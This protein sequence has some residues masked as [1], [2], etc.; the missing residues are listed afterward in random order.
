MLLFSGD[1]HF[2]EF[3]R[4]FTCR[5]ADAPPAASATATAKASA[6]GELWTYGGHAIRE[7]LS[8]LFAILNGSVS[9][10]H[11]SS[12]TGAEDSHPHSTR[13]PPTVVTPLVEVTSSGL[14]HAW[15]QLAGG[16]RIFTTAVNMAFPVMNRQYMTN[17]DIASGSHEPRQPLGGDVVS[18]YSSL[19][20]TEWSL[21]GRPP[22]PPSTPAHAAAAAR[23]GPAKRLRSP[24]ALHRAITS[25]QRTFYAHRNF[26]T[27]EL[28]WGDR[29]TREAAAA[30]AR[31]AATLGGTVA[32]AAEGE[33][34]GAHSLDSSVVV[35]IHSADTGETALVYP[36]AFNE[37][38]G[39]VVSEAAAAQLHA[40]SKKKQEL[41][42]AGHSV[43]PELEDEA[44]RAEYLAHGVLQVRNFH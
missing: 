23:A 2:A 33:G 43:P 17:F 3:T 4:S 24:L 40:A 10:G 14:T 18:P 32:G 11:A 12:S 6:P 25:P 39:S 34:A 35:R 30:G 36:L 27:I 37:L 44:R 22:P 7:Q 1:V 41:Q 20:L 13:L 15:G 21:I 29:G 38:R 26:A 31:H 28:V 9:T 42:A 5:A 16:D 19:S 8:S